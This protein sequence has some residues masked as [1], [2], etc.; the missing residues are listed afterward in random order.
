[1]AVE[2]DKII[3]TLSKMSQEQTKK[4][5]DRGDFVTECKDINFEEYL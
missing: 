5:C 2:I 4:I 3:R 1:M